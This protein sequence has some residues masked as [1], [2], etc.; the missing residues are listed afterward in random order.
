MPEFLREHSWPVVFS[1]VLH[2]ALAAALV[3]VTMI[4]TRRP[5]MPSQPIPINAVVVDSQVLHAA[6]RA[7]AER[8]AQEAQRARAA[9]EAQAA[10]E[11]HAADAAK[12][13]AAAK[14]AEEAQAAD[15]AKAAARQSRGGS[16][17]GR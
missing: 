14:A 5:P 16:Q 7:Q 15:A 2:G 11:A 10:A 3:L 4:S 17:G 6:Q 13:A 9:A 12:A 1:V 8:A